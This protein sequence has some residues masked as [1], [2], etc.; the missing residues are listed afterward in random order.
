MFAGKAPGLISDAGHPRTD[1]QARELATAG[2]N[3]IHS[4]DYA[5]GLL[6]LEDAAQYLGLEKD[7][8]APV[9]AVRYLCRTRKLRFL[10]VGKTLRFRRE[11]LDEYIDS[12][13]IAPIRRT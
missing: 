11:W 2:E 5:G 12:Q 13:S 4:V 1:E 8:Q 10:K 9:H 7:H 3:R 6:T